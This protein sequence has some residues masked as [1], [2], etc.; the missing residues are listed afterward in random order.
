LKKAIK[1]DS[2]SIRTFTLLEI[3][4]AAA[5]D[6]G[7]VIVDLVDIIGE[8]NFLHA[9]ATINNREKAWVKGSIDVGLEYG[10]NPKYKG[11]RLKDAF[12]KI[13]KFLDYD[14][15]SVIEGND[16]KCDGDSVRCVADTP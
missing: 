12:P 9:L 13:Y 3:Y 10:G 5:Y 1:K 2:T 4:D 15:D 6:H 7:G 8:D 14:R 16:T 11:K